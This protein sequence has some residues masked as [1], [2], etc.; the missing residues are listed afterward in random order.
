[1]MGDVADDDTD[2]S[3]QAPHEPC[4]DINFDSGDE[5][6]KG[7]MFLQ[8]HKVDSPKNQLAMSSRRDIPVT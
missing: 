3:I 5:L 8:P 2:V 6:F 1:M 7:L 4:P